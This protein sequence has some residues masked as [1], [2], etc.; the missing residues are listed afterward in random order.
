MVQMS[1]PD[2]FHF[3]EHFVWGAAT[4]AYQ[5]EGS[6]LADGAGPSIWHRFS[7]VPGRVRHGDTGDVACDHYRRY[8]EDI[9]W[10]KRLGLQSYR[11]SLSWSRVMP[12]GRGRV[13][14]AGLDHYQ[15]V[16]DALLEAGIRPNITLYHWDLPAAL[17]ERGGWLNPDISEWFADYAQLM[18]RALGDRVDLWATLNEP[19][20]VVDGG[21]M[22][23]VLAPGHRSHFEAAQASRHLMRAHGRAVQVARAQG[24]GAI[25]LVVNL[26]PKYPA[27]SS[28]AD[29][30]AVRRADA[31][32]NRQYLEPA[33]DGRLPPELAEVYGEA[34][35]D[36]SA[37]DLQL[38]SQKIDFLGINFYTR[39]VV[40]HDESAWPLQASP[41]MQTQAM[42]TETGW[43]V[44]PQAFEDLLVQVGQRYPDT[45]IYITENGSAFYDPPEAMAEP[46][47]DPHR[48]H[49]LHTH[50]WAMGRAMQRGV[51]IR[52]Y[53]AWSLLDNLEW[54]HGYSKRFGLLH[55]DLASQ[56]RTLKQ[57]ALAY[58]NVIARRSI[59]CPH[60][61]A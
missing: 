11:F 14:P 8:P 6:P 25:G 35:Q 27:S 12:E 17:D 20:V 30:Q 29:L 21:Y 4:A 54:A 56:K 9:A 1:N 37:D 13:N 61:Q 23:G 32:M 19:W 22:H 49:Y 46:L 33:L 48:A 3:P 31:Y 24:V 18:F 58:A 43:E 16:V 15:R 51:D 10:M 53:Y 52:G 5:V 47:P 59:R 38:A 39:A 60:A 45:P 42:H 40:R 7:H 2:E 34:W 36:W 57:S 50:L 26:E 44:C 28:E 55:V 41:V